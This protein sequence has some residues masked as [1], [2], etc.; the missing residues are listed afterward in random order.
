M[1]PPPSGF[2]FGRCVSRRARPR[3]PVAFRRLLGRSAAR[4]F[5]GSLR[6][7]AA[8]GARMDRRQRP[9]RE[10]EDFFGLAAHEFAHALRFLLGDAGQREKML[11]ST[12]ATV[13][14]SVARISFGRRSSSPAVRSS[15]S[16]SAIASPTSALAFDLASAAVSPMSVCAPA[17]ASCSEPTKSRERRDRAF[18]HILHPLGFAAEAGGQ[19]RCARRS[20][21]HQ[22]FELAVGLVLP[23]LRT[24]PLRSEASLI[25]CSIE[26]RS[27][28]ER[29]LE[30]YAFVFQTFSSSPSAARWR[31]CRPRTNS[32]R[33]MAASETASMRLD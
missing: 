2:F 20:V 30:G 13:L 26:A 24:S 27:V 25:A 4:A 21:G 14:D 23:G 15:R 8:G 22:M 7:L 17:P 33:A 29:A 18:R 3:R 5:C 12:S 32:A 19:L 9:R 10:V 6:P 16:H 28:S 31:S 1:S 11:R